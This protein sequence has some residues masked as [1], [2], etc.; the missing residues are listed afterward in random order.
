[1][2][3]SKDFY[4]INWKTIQVLMNSETGKQVNKDYWQRKIRAYL[5]V[6]ENDQHKEIGVKKI[7][8]KKLEELSERRKLQAL[9]N[10]PRKYN[11]EKDR[12]DLIDEEIRRAITQLPVPEFHQLQGDELDSSTIGVDYRDREG[13]LAFG[14]IHYGKEFK[15]LH[16]EYNCDIAKDRM[17]KLLDRTIQ[18][19]RDQQFDTI[20]V[21]ELGD[22][23]EGMDLR[24]SQL[25]S[26]QIGFVDQVIQLS[27]LLAS[28]INELSRYV[29][30]EYIHIPSANHTEI[31]PYN[32]KRGQFPD[33]DFERIIQEFINVSLKDNQRVTIKINKDGIVPF[34]LAGYDAVAMHGHQFNKNQRK[35]MI[36]NLNMMYHK[37]FSFLYFGHFHNGFYET[38]G[39]Y[40]DTN[41]EMIQVPSVMGSDKF[42]DS[43]G[44]ASKAGA[45]FDIYQKGEG[46]TIQYNIKLN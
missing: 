9:R 41:A 24:I 7:E 26:L 30:V 42:S 10:D 5:E 3:Q 33:E 16:N 20:K 36:K 22:S 11:R 21:I 35:N 29:R 37:F 1:M 32:T 12:H 13:V 34:K 40:D 4:G 2:E 6:Y 45:T 23:V 18:I 38:V 25:Q 27:K 19:V 46:R 31:R 39:A 43:L 28:W 8:Q 15:S 14:D 17:Q 44:L